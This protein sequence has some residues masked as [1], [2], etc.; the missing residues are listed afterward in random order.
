VFICFASLWELMI[1]PYQVHELEALQQ[2]AVLVLEAVGLVD[3]DASPLD[4]VEFGAA[5]Q[6]H[7]VRGD[8]GLEPVVA[9]HHT[10]LKRRGEH[11]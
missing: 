3:D 4:G 11:R 7:L 6:D 2:L 5:S 1:F 8:E 9:S 10:A